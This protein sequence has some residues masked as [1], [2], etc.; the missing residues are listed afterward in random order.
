LHVLP[1]VAARKM[2]AAGM[3]CVNRKVKL[4]NH[5]LSRFVFR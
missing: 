1:Y 3:S 2:G 4:Y 5:N